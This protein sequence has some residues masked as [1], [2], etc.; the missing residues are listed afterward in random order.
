MKGTIAVTLNGRASGKQ[1]IEWKQAIE[2]IFKPQRSERFRTPERLL[3]YYLCEFEATSQIR[4]L[5]MRIGGIVVRQADHGTT[6]GG[7]ER[8]L[9][10]AY[11]ECVLEIPDE[12]DGWRLNAPANTFQ[13]SYGA[14]PGSLECLLP[15]K[16]EHIH[17]VV[18]PNHNGTTADVTYAVFHFDPSAGSGGLPIPSTFDEAV[19]ALLRLLPL[20]QRKMLAEIPREE[21]VGRTHFSLGAAIRNDW[22]L[23]DKDSPL[24]R[25]FPG[26]EPDDVSGLIVGGVWEKLQESGDQ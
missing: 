24:M 22:H 14:L 13:D 26:M 6:E 1:I 18:V 11:G 21:V 23:W 20:E 10:G 12:G 4:D 8:D 3:H 15:P 19:E 9:L 25:Q 16:D 2:D 17:V 5:V 7:F